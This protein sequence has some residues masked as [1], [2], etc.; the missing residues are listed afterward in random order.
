MQAD[1]HRSVS[2]GPLHGS[3][4]ACQWP[5]VAVMGRPRMGAAWFD[6]AI[7]PGT[8]CGHRAWRCA[9]GG[10]SGRVMPLGRGFYGL[11]TV[12]AAKLRGMARLWRD[13]GTPGGRMRAR[14][15]GSLSLQPQQV[16]RSGRPYVGFVVR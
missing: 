13:R 2:V 16:R 10:A 5:R 12:G 6:I 14:G 9:E 15:L 4:G 8:P 3:G 7:S 1:G 11:G